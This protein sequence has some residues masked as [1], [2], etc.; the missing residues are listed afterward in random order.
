[1]GGV[2][3]GKLR[4]M[5]EPH[6]PEVLVKFPLNGGFFSRGLLAARASDKVVYPSEVE[7]STN[8]HGVLHVL[9]AG[10]LEVE[11]NQVRDRRE[12]TVV[13][14]KIVHIP[15]GGGLP[16]KRPRRAGHAARNDGEEGN[17]GVAR[18]KIFSK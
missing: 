14:L 9:T 3:A 5:A 1:M 12:G 8:V 17:V 18:D 4:A 11:L 15:P 7:V 2:F 13:D 10:D 6:L 16:A